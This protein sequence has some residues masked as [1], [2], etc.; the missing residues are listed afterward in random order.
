MIDGARLATPGLL[1]FGQRGALLHDRAVV[2]TPGWYLGADLQGWAIATGF[3]ETAEDALLDSIA[4][5]NDGYRLFEIATLDESSADAWFGPAAESNALF[6]RRQLWD[7]LGGVDE[8]FASPGGGFVNLDT[9]RRA[10]ALPGIDLVIL[11]GE[12]TM[13]QVHG[14]VAT[15]A[16]LDRYDANQ[17]RWTAEY[18]SIRGYPFEVQRPE[19]PPTF[20]GTLPPEVLLRLVRTALEPD[21]G[22]ARSPLGPEFDAGLW[23]THPA[24]PPTDPVIAALVA[25]ASDEFRARRYQA[26]V[27]LCRLIRERVPTEPAVLHML[28]LVGRWPAVADANTH[29]VM[30]EAYR[31]LGEHQHAITRYRAALDLHPGS[32]PA[33]RGLEQLSGH[34]NE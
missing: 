12:A 27:A 15:N 34:G 9:L 33:R 3:D 8:G 16:P 30:A 13:H 32:E 14:G 25:L 10:C 26:V 28:R 24:P 7:E 21:L 6:M 4:W 19:R 29:M 5:P 23:A 1:H 17:A 11:L 2:A 22:A 18:Q 31:V 20:L